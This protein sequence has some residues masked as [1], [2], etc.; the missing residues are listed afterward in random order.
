[1]HAEIVPDPARRVVALLLAEHADR[2]ALESAQ[3]A[4][5]RLVL[6]E[7][8]VAGERRELGDEPL[9]IVAEPRAPLGAR[10]LGLLPGREVGV[11]VGQRLFGPR[12]EPGDLVG[13]RGGIAL[14][15]DGPQFVETGVDVGDRRFEAEI[16]AHP[17]LAAN[18]RSP[19]S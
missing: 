2:L 12:L 6:A 10:D 3:A 15:R 4:D 17:V 11:E 18:R 1:R 14:F 13:D 7:I 5:D 8:T 9:E 16:G 19:T